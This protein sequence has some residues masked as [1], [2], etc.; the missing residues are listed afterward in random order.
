M[1]RCGVTCFHD[2]YFFPHVTAKVATDNG[3]RCAIGMPVIAFPT[4]WA[5]D[6]DD[7]IEKGNQMERELPATILLLLLQF[8]TSSSVMLQRYA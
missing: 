1:L 6:A 2:M 7:Y 4:N 3:M 5:K 8:L